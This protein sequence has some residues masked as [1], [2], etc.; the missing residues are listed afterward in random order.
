MHLYR[1]FRHNYPK[2][3]TMET[4]NIR[5]RHFSK[6]EI[7]VIEECL[8][9]WSYT[10]LVKLDYIASGEEEK[11]DVT[12]SLDKAF[13]GEFLWIIFGCGHEGVYRGL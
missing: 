9:E 7:R 1:C 8:Q 6:P 2:L 13:L 10:E 4:I 12:F 3:A 11:V 5:C